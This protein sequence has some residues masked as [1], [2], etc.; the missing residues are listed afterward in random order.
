M[1]I[2]KNL[3]GDDMIVLTK[4]EYDALIEDAGDAALADAAH[5]ANAGAPML[6]AAQMAAIAD[7]TAHPL[8]VWREAAGL[9][10]AELARRADIR[11]ATI[12]DIENG[13]IDPR[14]S[15]IKALA[16]ALSVDIDDIV[17]D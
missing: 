1:Q 8:A 11:P 13:N 3:T 6:N 7:G 9:S 15:T 2:A 10:Q 5:L 12:S 17:P 4:A 14:I 16:R